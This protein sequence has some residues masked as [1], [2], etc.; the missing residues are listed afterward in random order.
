VRPVDR[1]GRYLLDRLGLLVSVV[2]QTNY[3][4]TCS[5]PISNPYVHQR[6]HEAQVRRFCQ[7]V[8]AL[9]AAV[10]GV[11][12]LTVKIDRLRRQEQLADH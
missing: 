2:M 12:R 10:T 9:N 8:A 7:L 4:A 3:C 6:W 1:I 5:V 11:N